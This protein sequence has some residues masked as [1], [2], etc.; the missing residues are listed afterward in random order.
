MINLIIQVLTHKLTP[1]IISVCTLVP[2]GAFRKDS[3]VQGNQQATMQFSFKSE[4]P[5]PHKK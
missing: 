1:M 4:R 5:I 2:F 3:N